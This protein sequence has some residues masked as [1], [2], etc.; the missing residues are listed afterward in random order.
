MKNKIL[1][2]KG[3][4]NSFEKYYLEQIQQ[5][6]FNAFFYYK[7]S[8]VLRRL[9]THYG[10]PMENI[11]YDQWKKH[12]EKYDLII[13][14]DALHTENLLKYIWKNKK[15]NARLIYWHWNPIVNNND[16]RI[17]NRTKK[18]CEHWTFNPIDA[19]KYCMNINNQFFFEQNYNNKNE[20]EIDVFF[21][22]N[23]KGRYQLLK[24]LQYY[25]YNNG[26]I[27]KFAILQSKRPKINDSSIFI[28]SPMNY[29]DVISNIINCKAILELTQENQ[30]G[31]TIRALEALFFKKKLI[32]NNELIVHES[33]YRKENVFILNRDDKKYL[34]EFLAT[35][36]V[37]IEHNIL[38]MYCFDEWI[39]NFLNT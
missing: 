31:L 26:I 2:L 28:K 15:K 36:F 7:S 23:D 32:T 34:K 33:F 35:D 38:K 13:V 18:I 14:F 4:F 12:L 37:P 17:Y 16:K 22:G 20:Q 9:W 24:K 27:T 25:A 21:V 30:N 39:K 8:S 11:W 3:N 5:L 6:G 19:Q 10:I 29:N 1:L